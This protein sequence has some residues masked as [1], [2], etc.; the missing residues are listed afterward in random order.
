MAD[1]LAVVDISQR[2]KSTGE[3]GESHVRPMWFLKWLIMLALIIGLA[4]L[5]SYTLNASDVL[6]SKMPSFAAWWARYQ[7]YFMEGGATAVGL[8]L[9][10]RIGQSLIAVRERRTHSGFAALVLSIIAFA[11]LIHVCAK[12]ARLGWNGRGAWI[13]SWII[14]R[15]GYEAGRHIDK[16]IIV[17]TY[18]LKTVGFALLAGLALVAV[19]FVLASGLESAKGEADHN[20]ID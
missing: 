9:G 15:Q 1:Q 12:A 4:S 20:L 14:G 6:R 16:L 10:L 18:F 11:P 3:T 5:V 7:F 13:S 19:A 17:S 8:L 2:A